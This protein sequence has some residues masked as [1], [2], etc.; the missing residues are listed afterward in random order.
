MVEGFAGEGDLAGEGFVEEGPVGGDHFG[1]RHW[2]LVDDVVGEGGSVGGP[3]GVL[4][5][6]E[7]YGDR[8]RGEREEVAS[9]VAGFEELGHVVSVVGAST[10]LGGLYVSWFR[11][12]QNVSQVI[13]FSKPGAKR[14]DHWDNARY[15]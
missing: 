12:Q 11:L 3:C 1:E 2:R 7:E 9:P 5:K 13:V 6:P 14:E 4:P 15:V 8:E 10:D